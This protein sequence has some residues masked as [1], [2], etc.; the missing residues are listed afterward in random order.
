MVEGYSH[1]VPDNVTDRPAPERH[2][3]LEVADLSNA[4][5]AVY[6]ALIDLPPVTVAEARRALPNCG[7]RQLASLLEG[8][9]DKGLLTELPQLPRRYT[10]VSPDVALKAL[11]LEREER[12][13]RDRA[14][15]AELSRRYQAV[16]RH[17]A[18]EELLETVTGSRH[19]L[20]RWEAAMRSATREI[21]ALDRPPFDQTTSAPNGVELE[22]LSKGV[23][24]RVVYDQSGVRNDRVVERRRTEI[25]A[26]EQARMVGE[27]PI[28]LMLVD[29]RLALMPLHHDRSIREGL[30]IVHPCALLDA[31]SALFETIWR[32]GAPFTLGKMPGPGE[33]RTPLERKMT[34]DIVSLLAAGLNDQAV[35]RRLGCT[36]RTVHRH[37]QRV[38]EALG[39]QTRFQ[40][41]LQLGR[42]GWPT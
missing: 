31:L 10:P 38:A 39:A 3:L 19:A 35:A 30:L 12:L 5:E 36:E 29:H 17:G 24:A 13:Q 6:L 40:T 7:R 23:A 25:A 14:I 42:R 22:L 16:P 8:L 26:G 20:G 18:T 21:R 11:L 2:S 37:L 34:R 1:T 32:E 41:A 27:V 4:E 15:V 9:V 28:R 33:K